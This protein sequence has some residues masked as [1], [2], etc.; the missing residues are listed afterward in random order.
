MGAANAAAI[1]NE[2]KVPGPS[3]SVLPDF[4]V[5]CTV[6]FVPAVPYVTEGM[7]HPNAVAS[8]VIAGL[9]VTVSTPPPPL[10]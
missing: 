3:L 4:V 7:L 2:A 5:I 1:V 10:A 6:V 8:G 9:K